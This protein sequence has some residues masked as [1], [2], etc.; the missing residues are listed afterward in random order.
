MNE[1]WVCK[2]CFAD[3]EEGSAACQRCGLIRGA[4][5][6]ESDQAG[7]AAQGGAGSGPVEPAGWRRWVRYWWIPALAVVLAVGFL[8]NARRDDGGALEAAGTLSVDD[9][10]AGDCF[11]SG[12][13]TEISD[14]HG[15]P[16][17]E[18]HEYQA[19]AVA[20][21]EAAS[22]PGDAAMDTI[23]SSIC[24]GPFEA[25]VGEPYQ[26]SELWGLMITPSEESWGEGDRSF[27]CILHD[28]NNPQLTESMEG[29]NR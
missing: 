22:F 17:D 12:D 21:H 15:V 4:E 27:I 9:L 26:S 16:C 3:N 11:D 10:R 23:F 13:E 20:N 19:F 14:V 1:R 18:P 2:R 24:E 5:S 7:W 6:T 29:A 8:A 28:P 25:F